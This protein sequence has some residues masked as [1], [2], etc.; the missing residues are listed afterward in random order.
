MFG[1]RAVGFL[2]IKNLIVINAVGGILFLF[3]SGDLMV[4]KDYINFLGEN[5][6][7]GL[8]SEKFGERFFD[9]IYVYDR[10]I[11]EKVKD[12]Y[13]KNGVDYKEGVYVFLK[14]FLYEIFLE[15]KMLKIFGVDVVGMLIVLEV[16]AVR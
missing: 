6:V 2:G 13:K 11:I 5:L 12:V 8:D 1:V 9:M 14:G 10:E 15:I 16:I 7:I 3:F 4:I